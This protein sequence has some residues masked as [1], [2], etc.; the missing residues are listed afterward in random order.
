MKKILLSG[1]FLGLTMALNFTYAA[2]ITPPIITFTGATTILLTV[3]GTFADP[4]ATASDDVDGDITSNIIVNNP[5]NTAIEG[6]YTVTY[7]VKDATDNQAIEVSRTVIV[8][9][10]PIPVTII[11]KVYSGDEVLFD[12]PETVTACYESLITANVPETVNG[13]CAIEQSGLSNTWT[14]DYAPSGWLDELGGHATTPD[15]SKS[16]GWFN[17]LNYGNVALNQHPLSS[18]EELLL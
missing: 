6:T 1:I 9:P 16:W 12:G 17:N 14:W 7:N 18:D 13:K 11:L 10:V 3:N 2:D 5:V 4:G 8:N 15:Y